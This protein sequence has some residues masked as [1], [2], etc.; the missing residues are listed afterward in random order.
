MKQALQVDI[1]IISDLNCRFTAQFVSCGVIF[2]TFVAIAG[3]LV[4]SEDK[5]V[6]R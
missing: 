5:I 1:N 6:H 3:D 4:F 2:F